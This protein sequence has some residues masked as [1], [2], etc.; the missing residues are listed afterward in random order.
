[1]NRTKPVFPCLLIVLAA[2]LPCPAGAD[3]GS[4][5]L[6]AGIETWAQLLSR[7]DR[8]ARAGKLVEALESWKKGYLLRYPSYRNQAFLY[9]VAAQYLDRAGLREQLVEEFRKEMPDEKII[10]QQKALIAFG[11]LRPKTDLK[12][13]LFQLLTEEIAGF[14]DPDAK[15][16]RMIQE[17]KEEKKGIVGLL[18][19]TG[20]NLNELKTALV[21]E[22]SHALMD[23]HHD[24][25]SLQRSSQ[26]DDDMG[27]AVSALIEGEATLSMMVAQ[28]GSGN[29]EFLRSPPEAMKMTLGFLEPFLPFLGGSSSFRK[30]PRFLRESLT[31]P[32]FGGLIFC[33]SLT[34]P[35][36]AWRPVDTAFFNPP[37]STEQILH[38]ERYPGD[39]PVEVSLPDVA[40]E[41]GP[42]WSEVYANDLGE[43]TTRLLFEE[44]LSKKDSEL[45]AAGWDGDFYRVYERKAETGGGAGDRAVV[46]ASVWD[47]PEEAEE[48]VNALVRLF[49]ADRRF[50]AA[51]VGKKLLSRAERDG[52]RVVALL[53][54]PEEKAPAIEAKAS[55]FRTAPK[56]FKLQKAKPASG[57]PEDKRLRSKRV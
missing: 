34:S 53:F 49:N 42:G 8:E 28:E 51:E 50:A 2:G 37:V 35:T 40:P 55:K 45:A 7:G 10:A 14:Y 9:P 4:E 13:S 17:K 24:L 47:S 1:M 21:H 57:F 56:V 27:T 41:L 46:W 31:F 30:A 25:L 36:G 38:P 26:H 16:L 11:L 48:F 39:E 15:S 5:R 33:L 23:Q 54:V 44:K 29:L 32:Y 22:L 52:D 20:P 19:G 18:L 6:P 43:F 3:E 12:A